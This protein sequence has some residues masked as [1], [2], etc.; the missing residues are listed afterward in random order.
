M[1]AFGRATIVLLALMTGALAWAPARAAD[2]VAP[3][4]FDIPAQPL[5]GA[6]NSW[7]V[8]ATHRCS[9]SSSRLPPDVARGLRQHGAATGAPRVARADQIGVCSERRRS[10][11]RASRRN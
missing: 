4:T 10:V 6:L 8:Q 7:A 5:A 9:S 1:A 11:R 3:V 2:E